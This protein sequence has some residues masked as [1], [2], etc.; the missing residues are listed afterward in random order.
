MFRLFAILATLALASSVAACPVAV[1]CQSSV[2]TLAQPVFAVQAFAPVYS[3]PFAV[4]YAVPV[5]TFAVQ[6]QVVQQV[7]RQKAVLIQQDV[8]LR[9]HYRV[10]GQPIRNLFR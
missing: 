3:A 9:F 2:V 7:V 6:Q 4:Q 5:Q 1:Q 8:R 10:P